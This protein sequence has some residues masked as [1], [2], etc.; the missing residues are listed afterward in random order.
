MSNNFNKEYSV[1]NSSNITSIKAG[2]GA[3]RFARK[4][5]ESQLEEKGKKEEKPDTTTK[6]TSASAARKARKVGKVAV[7]V[8]LPLTAISLGLGLAGCKGTSVEAE[9]IVEEQPTQGQESEI[10]NNEV[11]IDSSETKE[12]TP[13]VV[14]EE[15]QKAVEWKGITINPIE[16][17][18]FDDGSFYPI[19]NRY[20]LPLNTEAGKVIIDAFEFNGKMENSIAL[21]PEVIEVLQKKALEEDKKFLIPLFFDF[22]TNK[23]IKIKEVEDDSLKFSETI[24]KINWASPKI[25]LVSNI[26]LGSIL[27][28]PV[29]SDNFM[30][31]KND[32]GSFIFGFKNLVDTNI[33]N[34]TFEGKKI[35]SVNLSLNVNGVRLLS[36][37][38]QKKLEPPL[39]LIT[40]I[41][42]GAPFGEVTEK[43]FLEI[44]Q[45]DS[46]TGSPT[47]NS[48]EF[49]MTIGLCMYQG[50]PGGDMRD[51]TGYLQT[52]SDN[53]LTL[54]TKETKIFVSLMPANEI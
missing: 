7:M 49:S 2:V 11:V 36:E 12:E 46:E 24:Q 17:L 6:D 51:T 13:P 23:N 42:I 29:N 21:R 48:N 22:E 14:E 54:G 52:A 20:N 10:K 47:F 30:I 41:K 15:P 40:N 1:G 4:Q 37:E 16:G 27:F 19:D 45:F 26:P 9:P 34:V 18:R 50:N 38:L 5:R 32:N 8:T 53:L 44:V 43:K 3:E 33:N 25:F 31:R 35:D 28:S 39:P